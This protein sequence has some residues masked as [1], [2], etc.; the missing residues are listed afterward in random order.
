QALAPL[1]GP[2]MSRA[3]TTIQIQENTGRMTSSTT[4]D[5][6]SHRNAD[7]RSVGGRSAGV[8]GVMSDGMAIVYARFSARYPANGKVRVQC[9][10]TSKSTPDPSPSGKKVK[11]R[12]EERATDDRPHDWKRIAAHAQHERLAKVELTRNP[13]SEQRA[14]EADGGR[15]DQPA[16]RA[17]AQRP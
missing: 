6:R 15:N 8:T 2:Y 11:E 3:I 10:A 12:Y 1:I 4:A 17:P 7:S 16:T 13:R 14:D 5:M 9:R